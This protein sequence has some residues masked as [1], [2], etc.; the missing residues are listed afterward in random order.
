[1]ID[2]VHDHDGTVTALVINGTRYEAAALAARLAVLERLATAAQA[3]AAA[4]DEAA[5]AVPEERKAA[6]ERLYA[7]GRA[8]RTALR[9][10][11]A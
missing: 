8:M 11:T 2:I 3:E 7:A 6:V 4:I 1:M 9:E 10:V 5:C